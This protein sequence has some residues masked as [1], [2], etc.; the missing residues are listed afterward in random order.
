MGI[1]LIFL[2]FVAAL[3]GGV[4]YA[5]HLAFYNS[6]KNRDKLPS[7]S[8]P[9]Y[10]PYRQ[11][12]ARIWKQLNDRPYETVTI[13][14]HDGL[15]LSG[16]Y[17]HIRDGAPLD[18]GFHGYRSSC[19]TDFSGGSELSFQLG[20][21]LLLVDE[22]AHGKSQG[23]TIS[24]GVRE[25]QDVLSWTNYAVCRFGPQVQILLYGVS[26][27]AATVLMAA[28]LDLPKN[29]RGII[30]D[31]PY[32]SPIEVMLHVGKVIRFPSLLIRPFAI[33]AAKVFGGFDLMEADA[34]EAVKHTPVPILILHGEADNFVPT[35]M[36]DIVSCNPAMITRHTFP[37]AAHG[38]SYLADTPRYQ[39]IVT[40]FIQNT[41]S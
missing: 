24:F 27:G 15:T 13:T 14:S 25:R 36:S 8:D 4:W 33:L 19:L 41:L 7:T 18:I 30:A 37:G 39:K 17:Y 26:M 12:M 32:A 34:R 3:L 5:Y 40:E 38:I 16:R 21:N 23:R 22:R 1:L 29:V 28:E 11:T 35:E 9:Q 31:C 20:H 6:M 2:I 10:D